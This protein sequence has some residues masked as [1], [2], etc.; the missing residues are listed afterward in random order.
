LLWI[1]EEGIIGF[2]QKKN[3]AKNKAP[4]SRILEA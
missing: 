4:K 3:N 1:F 2:A